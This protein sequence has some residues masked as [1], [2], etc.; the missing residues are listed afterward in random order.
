ME[1]NEESMTFSL[2]SNARLA[3]SRETFVKT[4]T[5]VAT[6]YVD[7][8]LVILIFFAI[9]IDSVLTYTALIPQ[10]LNFSVPQDEDDDDCNSIECHG[11][12]DI[13]DNTLVFDKRFWLITRV[14]GALTEDDVP[15]FEQRLAELYR[16]AFNRY[17]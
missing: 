1:G 15:N 6:V 8:N 11:D 10:K 5:V 17:N 7:G 9:E 3:A 12:G 14:G 2:K 16:I 13:D 4:A